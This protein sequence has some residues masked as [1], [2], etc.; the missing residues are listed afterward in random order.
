MAAVQ[1]KEDDKLRIYL[2]ALRWSAHKMTSGEVRQTQLG[3]VQMGC[4]KRLLLQLK[5]AR[6]INCLSPG[7]RQCHTCA[8]RYGSHPRKE[9]H[10]VQP[11]Q[12]LQFAFAD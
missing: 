9:W 12:P 8:G 1:G 11:L 7:G 3:C 2:V 10:L 4:Q 6:S 5:A